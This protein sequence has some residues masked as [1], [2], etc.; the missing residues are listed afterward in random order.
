MPR[1]SYMWS[2]VG[3]PQLSGTVGSGLNWLR[4]LLVGSG[5]SAYGSKPSLGWTEAYTGI[6]Q[7]CFRNSM[8]EGGSGCYLQ[9]LDTNATYTQIRMYESMSAVNSGTA[10]TAQYRIQKA[11]EP[12]GTA[13]PWQLEGDGIRFFA[14]VLGGHTENPSP[15]ASYIGWTSFVGGGNYKSYYPGDPAVFCT[16]RVGSGEWDDSGPLAYTGGPNL[17]SPTGGYTTLT[18]N[19]AISVAQTAAAGMRLAYG[20][21]GQGGYGAASTAELATPGS[22]ALGNQYHPFILMTAGAVRGCIPGVFIPMNLIAPAKAIIGE[23]DTP[24]STSSPRTL[25]IMGSGYARATEIGLLAFDSGE[26]GV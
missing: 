18:R 26:W 25:R 19:N 6:N 3:A 8:A 1:Q 7:A 16:G 9:V 4:A 10:P 12:G 5:G 21:V 23:T 15:H 11:S 17:S 22:G 2:D 13:R 24:I 20:G 14:T